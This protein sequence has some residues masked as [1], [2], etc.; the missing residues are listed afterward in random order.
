MPLQSVLV[1]DNYFLRYIWVTSMAVLKIDLEWF[2]CPKGYRLVHAREVARAIGTD[3]M[4]YPNE[5]WIVPIGNERVH[6]RPFEEYEML[7]IAFAKLETPESLMNFI[8]L[9]GPITRTSPEWGDSVSGKLRTSRRF[10]EL[11]SCK[12]KGP[13][14]LA[15]VFNFQVQASFAAAYKRAVKSPLPKDFDFGT[16][17]ELVGMAD[18]VADAKRGIQLRITTDTLIGGLWWQL[19]QK[20]S[21]ETN[22]QRCRYCSA[23]FETGPG[24][25]RH[26]DAAFC[27]NEHKVRF[28]SLARSKRHKR[29]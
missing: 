2:R 11:L 21:G 23:P 14:K 19:A 8:K 12:E 25:G 18:I 13:R 15:S 16:P 5:D 29:N 4:S 10:R 1:T 9:Y 28:F 24:T 6:Y 27:S 17:N 20:L 26:V 22:I 3:P 7:C